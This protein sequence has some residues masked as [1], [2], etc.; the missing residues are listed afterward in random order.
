MSILVSFVRALSAR[1]CR[2][3]LLL[4]R[5]EL[6]GELRTRSARFPQCS[7]QGDDSKFDESEMC[8][9]GAFRLLKSTSGRFVPGIESR[10]RMKD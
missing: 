2:S 10:S 7:G 6:A 1:L 3:V 4:L 9:P 5:S 8:A